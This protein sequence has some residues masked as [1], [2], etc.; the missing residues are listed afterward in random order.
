[1]RNLL[2][3]LS[4]CLSSLCFAQTYKYISV[5]DGLSNR[6]VY[7]IHKDKKGY[8]WFLTQEGI[9]RYDGTLFKHYNLIAGNEKISSFTDMNLLAMDKER[10]LWEV[11]K[12]GQIFKYNIN[13]DSYQLV[14]QIK[15]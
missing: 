7:N 12:K 15:K 4:L 14:F 8:M 1:M 11:T 9:D 5:E 6:R 2:F 10:V 13:T 3:A